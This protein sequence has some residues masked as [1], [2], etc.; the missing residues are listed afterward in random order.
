MKL[1]H[2][3]QPKMLGA[4][5][6]HPQWPH[7]CSMCKFVGNISY[8]NGNLG[9]V[10]VCAGSHDDT[11]LIRFGKEP[12]DYSS[13][14]LSTALKSAFLHP[15]CMLRQAL[16]LCVMHN[17]VTDKKLSDAIIDII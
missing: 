12:H 14:D 16:Y 6:D 17:V 5:E 7:N 9:D 15:D 1:K 2:W 13:Y 3:A 4:D 8:T 11:V 10:Y